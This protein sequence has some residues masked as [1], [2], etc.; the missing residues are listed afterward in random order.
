MPHKLDVVTGT[1]RKA[2]FSVGETPGIVRA[3]CWRRRRLH[4]R[5]ATAGRFPGLFRYRPIGAASCSAHIAGIRSFKC[6]DVRRGFT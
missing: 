4:Q 5:G 2:I 3:L 6:G 1:T